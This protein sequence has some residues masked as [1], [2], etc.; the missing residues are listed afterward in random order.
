MATRELY[1]RALRMAIPAALLLTVTRVEAVP[2]F[3]RQTGMACEA[4]HTVYPELTHF[5]RVFKANGYVLDNLKQVRDIDQKKQQLLEL[6][7]IPPLSI[8]AQVSYTQLRKPLPDLANVNIPGEAQNGTAAFPQQLSIFYAGKIAPHFGAFFQITYGNDSG[9]VSIDNTDL[10]FADI[11]ILPGD[12]SLVYGVSLNNN[13]TV[14]DLW[15]STPAFGFPYAAS[16]A[17]VS[18][19]AGTQID[20]TLGQDVAGLT[21]YAFWNESL[22]AEI[23]GYRSAKQGAANQLTGAAGPLDGTISNV[24]SGVAPYWRVGYEYNWSRHSI[25]VGAYGLDVR[26]FPGGSPAQPVPLQRPYNHF[27]DVAEDFQYQYIDDLNLVTV[28]G[29]RIH[30]TMNLDASVAANLSANASNNLTTS[31]LW[32]TYYYRRRIG[33]TLGFFSTTGSTDQV[34]YPGSPD[35]VVGVTT[36]ANGSP[37]TRGWVAEVNYLPWLNTKL[38][39]QYTAYT[40]FNGGSTAYDGAGRN[41]SDNNTL[42]LLLWFAY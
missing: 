22:Y 6:A 27:K 39:V 17:T 11:R 4:C 24:I 41:A 33:G 25:E 21:A 10:R 7:Q 18:P 32:A 28:A 8:M 26:M 20:G 1:L 38:S 31:R 23:G 3:A 36:S 14:Q 35:G 9:T 37:N 42:Y 16:N 19:L 34:L 15:N 29:T 40:K 13:P 12:Q 2:S 5:G 30:E